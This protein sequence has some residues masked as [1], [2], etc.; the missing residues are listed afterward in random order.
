MVDKQLLCAYDADALAMLV[1]KDAIPY[2]HL[3]AEAVCF[4]SSDVEAVPSA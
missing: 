3:R 1:V 2:E 4:S